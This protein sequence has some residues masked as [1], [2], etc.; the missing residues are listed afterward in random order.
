VGR[1]H[2]QAIESMKLEDNGGFGS[3]GFDVA[4]ETGEFGENVDERNSCSERPR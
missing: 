1:S 2:I 4:K 3:F